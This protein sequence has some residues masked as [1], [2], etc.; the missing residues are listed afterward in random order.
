M[1]EI[2]NVKSDESVAGNKLRRAI[3]KII[4]KVLAVVTIVVLIFSPYLLIL[5]WKV[6]LP[7]VVTVWII[8]AAYYM[9]VKAKRDRE[10]D[11]P[12]E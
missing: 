5:D 7:F 6:Y 4:K 3:V 1:N 2:E 11:D 10:G 9:F 12:S 8:S